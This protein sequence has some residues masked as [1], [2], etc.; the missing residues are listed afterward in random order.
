MVH[1][2][3]ATRVS[4][5]SE[6]RRPMTGHRLIHAKVEHLGAGRRAKA[7]R[8]IRS[9]GARAACAVLVLL[10]TGTAARAQGVDLL[11]D[12]ITVPDFLYT[13]RLDTTTIPGTTLLR[14]STATANNGM[15]RLEIRGGAII[16]PT[17][18]QV[19]QR[20]YRSDGTFY[21]RFA[22]TFTYH[23]SH[24][25]VHFDDWS[26][27][28]LRT[29]TEDGGVG[30]VVVEGA[31]ESF[32]L[33]DLFVYDLDN[34]FIPFPPF[35]GTCGFVQGISPGWGDVYDLELPDQWVDITGVPDGF[36]WLEAEV[37][38]LDRILESDETNN[39]SRIRLWIGPPPDAVPDRFEE[40][41]SFGE[42]DAREEG[43][44]N[45]PNLGLVNARR[46]ISDLSMEDDGDYFKFRMN[47]T[48]DEGDYIRMESDYLVG[49]DLDLE[50]FDAQGVLIDLSLSPSSVEQISL[51][52]RP[53]GIYYIQVHAFFG[54]NPRYRLIIDPAANGAPTIEVIDPAAPGVLVERSFE[55]LPVTW[56][57]SDPEGDPTWVSLFM[58]R[59]MT[60]D[61]ATL[62]IGGYQKLPGASGAANVNT[63]G[64][65]LGTW[66]LYARITD[67]GA[68]A[69]AWAPGSFTVYVKGDVNFDGRVDFT[70][71]R[72]VLRALAR[73]NLPP[74]WQVIAD[75]NRD[76][77]VNLRDILLLARAA[78]PA[79]HEQP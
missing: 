3:G 76:G 5:E 73:H 42:V 52:G 40:N 69:D 38:P 77:Y 22:G 32:C 10:L 29:I 14:F 13:T 58:D 12:V 39:A 6:P 63:T 45:S 65:G 41:D 15:G 25:H 53:A 47:N 16:S 1:H 49:N 36:Y 67:G 55:A 30:E 57:A 61:K 68:M 34:P 20:I 9:K 56:T 78:K 66:Y 59:D 46:E 70:D 28:R 72:S 19:N 44:E 11:P 64:M 27:Y 51:A 24:G 37:D 18:R 79:G 74:D 2:P 43:G 31:K 71:F 17:Q 7:L 50:L 26:T 4:W 35:Y 21:D 48:G 62:P 33:F 60:L 8:L 75:M 54:Q 23:S